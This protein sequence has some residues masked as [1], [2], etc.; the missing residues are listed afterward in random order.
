[1]TNHVPKSDL[2]VVRRVDLR[3]LSKPSRLL[4][5]GIAALSDERMVPLDIL[6]LIAF[7]S[8][9]FVLSTDWDAQASE[10]LIFSGDILERDASFRALDYDDEPSNIES[11]RHTRQFT[12]YEF[13]RTGYF[14]QKLTMELVKLTEEGYEQLERRSPGPPVIS[15][16]FVHFH[17]VLV[18]R[19]RLPDVRID[20]LFSRHGER[21]A[22]WSDHRFPNLFRAPDELLVP[23]FGAFHPQWA[24]SDCLIA[25]SRIEDEFDPLNGSV[26][27]KVVNQEWVAQKSSI[28]DYPGP[29]TH[30]FEYQNYEKLADKLRNV[31][32]F[33]D[34]PSGQLCAQVN[35]NPLEEFSLELETYENEWDVTTSDPLGLWFM[36]TGTAE[37]WRIEINVHETKVSPCYEMS[38]P[39]DLIR[40]GIIS[41]IGP[42]HVRW[43]PNVEDYERLYDVSYQNQLPFGHLEYQLWGAW[44]DDVIME[45][46]ASWSEEYF[47]EF[48]DPIL[49]LFR[50]DDATLTAVRQLNPF[51]ELHWIL[52]HGASVEADGGVEMTAP[53]RHALVMSKYVTFSER[54]LYSFCDG[55]ENANSILVSDIVTEEYSRFRPEVPAG[56]TSQ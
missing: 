27:L 54:Y 25:S 38:R 49:V 10:Y 19:G 47:W 30:I 46:L 42:Q 43:I 8:S 7:E 4:E 3:S 12:M 6:R 1:M 29:S 22:V 13:H 11:L 44:G 33:N 2:P 35:R 37:M 28:P 39:L 20:Y 45:V 56:S 41:V 15:R 16:N 51:K 24:A 9:V 32:M 5:R 34:H 21:L 36:Q 53:F 50:V 40:D 17:E 26:K 48:P 23:I 52:W 55:G 14:I 31:H 18:M